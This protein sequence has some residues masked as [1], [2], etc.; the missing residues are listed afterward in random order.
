MPS[1]RSVLTCSPAFPGG[2]GPV[3]PPACSWP[4]RD[5]NGSRRAILGS[6]S[7][8][9]GFGVAEAADL[10]AFFRAGFF[11]AGFFAAGFAAAGF[12]AAGFVA[13]GGL[14]ACVAGLAAGVAG[15][16]CGVAAG[17]PVFGGSCAAGFACACGA[18]LA[19]GAAGVACAC[20]LG[21]ATPSIIPSASVFTERIKSLIP[22]RV[23][24]P[25]LPGSLIS[26]PYPPAW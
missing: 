4:T 19:A 8:S 5:S 25:A 9:A 15:L 12:V 17:A 10:G 21:P 7:A 23:S 13:C 20:K 16:A 22:F 26:R 2:R 6:L 14:A 24:Q 3:L 18:G 11:A 1:S